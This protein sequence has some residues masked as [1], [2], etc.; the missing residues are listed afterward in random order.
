M[1]ANKK[2]SITTRVFF[3]VRAVY[4]KCKM[5]ARIYSYRILGAKIGENVKLGSVF[6]TVPEQLIIGNNCDIEDHVRLRAGGAW[7]SASI[8]IDDNTYI[9]HST[10]VNVRSAFKIGKKCLIAPL[11]IFSDAHHTFTDINIPIKDQETTS[12]PIQ[13]D[14]NVWIGTGSIILGGVTIHSGAIVAAGAVVNCS[15]PSNEIW[16]GVPAKKIKSRT[17]EA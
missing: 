16:G 15:I 4:L 17:Q 10:Q 9:G 7:K 12:V 2:R 6:I 5:G 8:F 13:I 3:R 1:E 11:C 14:D